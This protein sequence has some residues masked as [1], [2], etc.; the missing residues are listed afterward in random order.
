[1]EILAICNS[2]PRII[3]EV[4]GDVFYSIEEVQYLWL[5]NSHIPPPM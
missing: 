2:M 5:H 1:M 3:K 4:V